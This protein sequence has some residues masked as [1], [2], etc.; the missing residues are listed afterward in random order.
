MG[1][2]GAGGRR[3]AR[4]GGGSNYCL[5]FPSLCV[6]AS[7]A[8]RRTTHT[9]TSLMAILI[10]PLSSALSFACLILPS[11]LPPLPCIIIAQ[12]QGRDPQ[13][14]AAATA[15]AAAKPCEPAPMS[16]PSSSEDEDFPPPK[17][18]LNDES[19]SDSDSSDEEDEEEGEVTGEGSTKPSG[20]G[21]GG[22]GGNK[23]PKARPA[24]GGGSGSEDEDSDDSSDEEDDDGALP[25]RKR[26]AEGGGD[27]DDDDEEDDEEEDDEEEEEE[28]EEEEDGQNT[29]A[30][31]PQA[32]KGLRACRKCRLIKEFSQFVERGC[33]NC[34]QFEDQEE[35]A[36]FTSPHFTGM[37]ALVQPDD[38]WS[39]KW[40]GAR[41]YKPG[42]Y[43][44]QVEGE[45]EFDLEPE[46]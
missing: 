15:A 2:G 45:E 42:L 18:P 29:Y 26:P 27:S 46:E 13:D 44:L 6:P 38:S 20:G 35:A 30:E 11:S 10:M 33:D 22:G 32:T 16:S 40:Q 24:L 28:E 8:H 19:S 17:A 41:R 37:M 43:A 4:R 12:K 39:A 3:E 14:T 23:A 36:E 25:T 34:R 21:G 9:F 5:V 31:L 7:H 1:C